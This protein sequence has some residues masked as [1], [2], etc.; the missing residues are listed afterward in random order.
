MSDAI[1]YTF[2]VLCLLLVAGTPDITDAIVN[3]LMIGGCE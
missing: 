1:F 2:V 3:N